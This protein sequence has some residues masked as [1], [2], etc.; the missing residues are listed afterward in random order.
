MC[1]V[2]YIPCHVRHRKRSSILMLNVGSLHSITFAGSASNSSYPV[3][4]AGPLFTYILLVRLIYCRFF[5]FR[6]ES[7]CF[8]IVN[9]LGI[10]AHNLDRY[11][12]FKK[13]AENNSIK[14]IGVIIHILTDLHFYRTHI[15]NIF[16]I[17]FISIKRS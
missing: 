15:F 6:C 7:T 3:A 17:L 9:V 12:L 1:I 2:V 5:R 16:L 10:S 8:C 14:L 11:P 4:F 13:V